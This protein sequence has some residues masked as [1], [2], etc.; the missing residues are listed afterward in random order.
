[1]AAWSLDDLLKEIQDLEA[2]HALR[3]E[4]KLVTNLLKG[5]ETKVKA[6]DCLTPSMLV[7]LTEAL[8]ASKLPAEIKQSLQDLVEA[9]AVEA[10]A[11][12]LKLQSQP[13][14]M[15]SL[16]NY[17]SAKEW[18]ALEQAPFTQA[19]QLCVRRMKAVGIR[20]MKET[21]KKHVVALV[22]HLML[23]RG[24]PKPPGP[25]IYKMGVYLLDSLKASKQQPLVPGLA[26]YPD[27]PLEISTDPNLN[28]I[29]QGFFGVHQRLSI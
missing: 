12:T 11:G 5:L 22:I 28:L 3:P 24:E 16:Q 20:S 14:L 23:Q 18:K 25:E 9:R 21:T 27:K 29:W 6:M 7:K 19:M 15:V 17:M 4:S 8:N 1:M 26:T 10:N 2:L 13:Q